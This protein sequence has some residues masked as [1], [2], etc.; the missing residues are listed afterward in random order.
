MKNTKI[1]CTIGPSSI[2][3]KIIKRMFLHGMNAARLNTAHGDFDFYQKA[4]KNIRETCNIPIV[5]DIKGPDLR[6]KTSGIHEFRK[7]EEIRVGK[8]SDITLNYDIFSQVKKND[9]ILMNDGKYRLKIITTSKNNFTM[10]S[11]ENVIIKP[12]KNFN[13]PSRD[14]DLPQL[15]SKDKKAIKFVNDNNI[16]YVALSFCRNK[17]D[18]LN[19][20][21][22]LNSEIKIISKIENHQGIKNIAEIIEFSD[23]V[24][25][26]RGDLGVELPPEQVPLI[27]KKIIH[28]CN[29]KGKAVIVATQMLESM[30]DNQTPTRAETS[31]VANAVLDGADCLMLSEETAIG[32]FPDEAVAYMSRVARI[33]EPKI[34]INIQVFDNSKIS[35]SISYSIFTLAKTLPINKIICLTYSGYT[36]SKIARFRISK[37][38]LA[39]TSSPMVAK[40]LMIY[41]SINPI[42]YGSNFWTKPIISTAKYLFKKKLIKKSELL[43]FT[44]GLNTKGGK[45][46]NTIQIHKLSDLAEFF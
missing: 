41:Y 35:D 29:Q 13:I 3:K 22:R 15:N 1:L 46:T 25:I 9:I 2:D 33:T 7:G 32:K 23:A 43:L 5:I 37:P 12:D 6:I 14:L 21:K 42:Y 31:D 19:L 36:A 16:E 17:D 27:Q 11:K 34:D 44:A 28:L 40:Q 8:N 18:L 26:A 10:A 39:V 38:I 20:R 24:M 4:I 30:V 45:K